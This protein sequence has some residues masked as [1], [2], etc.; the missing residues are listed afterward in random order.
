MSVRA[1]CFACLPCCAGPAG[2]AELL[3][4][5]PPHPRR[6]CAGSWAAAEPQPRARQPRP[7]SSWSGQSAGVTRLS[8]SPPPS[9]SGGTPPESPPR[10]RPCSTGLAASGSTCSGDGTHACT[11]LAVPA[12]GASAPPR[13]PLSKPWPHMPSPCPSPCRTV[14][15]GTCAPAAWAW[16]LGAR[17]LASASSSSRARLRWSSRVLCSCTRCKSR[18]C[19]AAWASMPCSWDS[20]AWT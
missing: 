16:W 4:P 5:A 7:A 13:P 14:P 17:R 18:A 10:A 20:C 9:A 8:S 11:G 2:V 1:R 12:A 19:A 3:G 15:A 6:Q